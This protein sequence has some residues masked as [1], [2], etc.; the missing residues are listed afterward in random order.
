MSEKI[1]YGRCVLCGGELREKRAPMPF[2]KRG[3]LLAII[4]DVPTGICGQCGGKEFKIAVAK[5]LEKL[6]AQPKDSWKRIKVPSLR[7]TPTERL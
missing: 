4:E 7:Y 1:T 2:Y 6:L 5:R 3:Q